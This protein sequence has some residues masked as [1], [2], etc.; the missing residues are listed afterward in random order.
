MSSPLRRHPLLPV[1]L[2]LA[3][4]IAGGEWLWQA[5]LWDAHTWLGIGSTLLIL[6]IATAF[7]C[8]WLR[9]SQLFFG[10]IGGIVLCLGWLRLGFA[11]Q[12]VDYPFTGLDSTYEVIVSERPEQKPKT[13]LCRTTLIREWQA[14]S[15]ALPT[16]SATFYVY[17]ARDSLSERIGRGDRLKVST[18]L[19]PPESSHIPDAFDYG[20]YLLHHGVSG[21][22]YV[23]EGGWQRVGHDDRLTLRQRALDLRDLVTARY[24]ALGFTGDEMATVSALTVG[25]KDELSE[26]IIETYTATGARHV[27]AMS[28][29]HVGFVY[30]VLLWLLMPLCRRWGWMRPV[31]FLF[32]V[33]ALWGFAFLTGLSTS[34]VRAV[35]MCSL[36]ILLSL[37]RREKADTMDA[38]VVTALCML[39]YNPFWLTD[40]GFQLSVTA[41]AGICLLQPRLFPLLKPRNVVGRYVWELLTLSVTAQLATAPLVMHYFARFP[42]HFLLTNLW[43]IPAVTL[44]MY[45]TALLLLLQPLPLLQMAL[46]P[47]VC[48]LVWVQ[49][50]VLQA[51]ERLPWSSINDIWLGVGEVAALYLLGL[52]LLGYWNKPTRPRRWALATAFALVL[53]CRVNMLLGERPRSG[54]AFYNVRGCPAVVCLPVDG[55]PLLVCADSLTD[56]GYYSNNIAPR[57]RH[58]RLPSPRKVGAPYEEGDLWVAEDGII[59]CG[60]KCVCLVCDERWQGRKADTPFQ[61]DY[62]LIT[63]GYWGEVADLVRAFNI[64]HV[65]L[66]ASL[67]EAR[68][69]AMRLECFKKGIACTRLGQAGSLEDW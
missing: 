68:Q 2:L 34:V 3:V 27:L 57:L 21:T 23:A 43:I 33:A 51:I 24:R 55:Q 49:N 11:V 22:A 66:D 65:V 45:A 42:L 37:I 46:A 69:S 56:V 6:L 40:V 31:A 61:V 44:V 36:H 67:S 39:L 26:E 13:V 30:M 1:L 19:R 64:R 16:R 48:K 15:T 41:V 8:H 12:V 63:S 20:R 60:G 38:L 35:V 59:Y 10:A 52:V 53:A 58:L 4:G 47:L 17:I 25:Y 18:R 29:L 9:W 28:G 54:L 32:T 62:A 7:T 14:D 5:G 50:A